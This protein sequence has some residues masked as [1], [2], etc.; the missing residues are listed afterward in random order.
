MIPIDQFSTKTRQPSE[1][2]IPVS[3]VICSV[4]TIE[5][6]DVVGTMK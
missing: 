6:Y 3:V 4:V 5:S 2:M 1:E